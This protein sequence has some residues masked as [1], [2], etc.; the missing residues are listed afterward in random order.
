MA[1]SSCYDNETPS[2]WHTSYELE[3]TAK[4][5]R[6]VIESIPARFWIASGFGVQSIF[7]DEF[8]G[9]VLGINGLLLLLMDGRIGDN[10][11]FPK[12]TSNI[13]SKL[14]YEERQ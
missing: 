1:S 13:Y 14:I 11:W 2:Q 10:F 8:K 7:G 3:I 6:F 9:L 5:D 12:Q 4:L